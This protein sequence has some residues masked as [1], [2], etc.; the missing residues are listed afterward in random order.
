MAWLIV[1]EQSGQCLGD[2]HWL[3]DAGS[4][5]DVISPPLACG[6]CI[7]DISNSWYRGLRFGMLV[8][9]VVILLDPSTLT[10]HQWLERVSATLLLVPHCWLVECCI[11]IMSPF[12]SGHSY[13]FL[14]GGCCIE[15]GS[16][17]DSKLRLSILHAVYIAWVAMSGSWWWSRSSPGDS[18]MSGWACFCIEG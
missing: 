16:S 6:A 14:L 11:E 9:Q 8:F 12:R 7:L 18:P 13:N 4:L 17:H 15:T 5:G 1:Q 10:W 2:F 3:S